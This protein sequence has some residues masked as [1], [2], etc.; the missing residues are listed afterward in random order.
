VRG[1]GQSGKPPGPYSVKQFAADTVALLQHLGLDS[2]HLIGVSMGG[3]IAFQM[4]VDAPDTVSS[5][6]IINSGPEVPMRTLK[7]RI[8]IWQRLVL[9]RLF[10]MEK[11]GETIGGRL[12]PAEHQQAMREAFTARWAENDKRSYLTATRA[13]AGWS[14]RDHIRRIQTPTLVI[15]ADQDYTPVADKE[16][17]VEQMLNAQLLVID[18]ARH[19]VNFAQPEKV[20]PAILAFLKQVAAAT[21]QGGNR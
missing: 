14:V 20:N 3:M 12:F 7:D 16:A 9:F 5:M 17:Y 2:A 13:L 21:D 4:A 10:S 8:A 15:A 19:A 18:D 1:H 11:I 6:V